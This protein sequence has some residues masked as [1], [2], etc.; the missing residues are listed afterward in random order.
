MMAILKDNESMPDNFELITS[1]SGIGPRTA[2]FVIAYT[3]NSTKFKSYRKFASHCGIA[4]FQNRSG[5][6][7][8]GRTEVGDLANKKMKASLDLCARSSIQHNTEMEIH[9]E[10]RVAQGKNKMST[11]NIIRD[12]LLSRI[13]AVVNGN[14]PY[15]DTMK[16][17]A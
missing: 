16:Y 17:A 5:T 6:S 2:L 15:V 12:K 10:K 11:M 14:E 3:A 7:V 9:Y 8:R 1:I 13:F 4:P